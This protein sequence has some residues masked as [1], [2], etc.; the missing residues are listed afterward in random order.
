MCKGE[1][2]PNG[3]QNTKPPNFG[4]NMLPE[5]NGQNSEEPW[6]VLGHGREPPGNSQWAGDSR[7]GPGFTAEK[8]CGS[9]ECFQHEFLSHAH[10]V[11]LNICDTSW[12][13][14]MFI[15]YKSTHSLQKMIRWEKHAFRLHQQHSTNIHPA[16]K[17]TPSLST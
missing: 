9:T 7:K 12:Q 16:L 8:N 5:A 6:D 11:L 13:V 4:Q 17:I 2:A 10:E 14:K 3:S 1:V 15:A